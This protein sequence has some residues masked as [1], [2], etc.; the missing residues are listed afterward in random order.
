MEERWL[1]CSTKANEVVKISDPIA[2]IDAY[3]LAEC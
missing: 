1:N 3:K 2:I